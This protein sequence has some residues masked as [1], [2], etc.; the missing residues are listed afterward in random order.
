MV[1]DGTTPDADFCKGPLPAPTDDFFAA[2][3]P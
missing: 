2:A 1:I 3:P